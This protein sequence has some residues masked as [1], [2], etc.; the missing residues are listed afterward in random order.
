MKLQY[1][2]VLNDDSKKFESLQ[3][4]WKE[5]DLIINFIKEGWMTES[6]I[7]IKSYAFDVE[8]RSIFFVFRENNIIYKERIDRKNLDK[9][10]YKEY[11]KLLT[12]KNMK[13]MEGSDNYD[14]KNIEGL[15]IRT[16]YNNNKF[17]TVW[18]CNRIIDSINWE[19]ST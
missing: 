18:G 1:I 2:D 12:E 4:K 17:P 5:D 19:I 3:I 11:L 16:Y 10:T 9:I 14:F 7:V 15:E 6:Y 8:I 13:L